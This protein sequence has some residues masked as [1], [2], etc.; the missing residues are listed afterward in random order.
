MKAGEHV[1]ARE[2]FWGAHVT[3]IA[4][5]AGCSVGS[6]Y[7]RFKDK[8]ALFFALQTDMAEHAKRNIDAAFD[9]P[10]W[11]TSPLPEMFEQLMRNTARTI[12]RIQ[13]YYRALYEMSL[14]GHKVWDPMRAL[15]RHQGERIA[16]M[17]EARGISIKHDDVVTAAQLAVR[18]IN[19]LLISSVIHQAAPYRSDDPKLHREMALIL[20]RYLGI[21]PTRTRKERPKDD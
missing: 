1:F 4:E 7:R 17:L 21:E 15:E 19:G 3:Q 11:L 20:T 14:R 8:E 6:F 16:G 2:G 9:D 12:V 5:E 18:M 10:N 13:G